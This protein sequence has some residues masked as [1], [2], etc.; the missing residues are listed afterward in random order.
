MHARLEFLKTHQ[1]KADITAD[2]DEME[3]LLE[4]D[5]VNELPLVVSSTNLQSSSVSKVLDT[6]KL[7]KQRQQSSTPADEPKAKGAKTTKKGAE[8]KSQEISASTVEPFVESATNIQD[9]VLL[10]RPPTP[11]KPKTI[12]PPIELEPFKKY[13][14]NLK[15]IIFLFNLFF[16]AFTDL[17][18]YRY[19]KTSKLKERLLKSVSKSLITSGIFVSRF[20]AFVKKSERIQSCTRQNRLKNARHFK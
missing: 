14:R 4:E 15:I 8:A 1:V 13:F 3:K 2:T 17:Q 18:M 19:L 12:L 11:P 10:N 16:I 5:Q 6:N 7:A 9:E 20:F